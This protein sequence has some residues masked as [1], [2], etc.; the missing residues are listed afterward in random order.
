[1]ALLVLLAAAIHKG[2]IYCGEQYCLLFYLVYIYHTDYFIVY[3]QEL[4]REFGRF[5]LV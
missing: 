1:M 4:L 3:F 5:G 2:G